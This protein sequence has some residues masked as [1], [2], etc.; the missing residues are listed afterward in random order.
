MK[1]SLSN[2]TAQMGGMFLVMENDNLE[3]L[4]NWVSELK[5]RCIPA[6]IKVSEP[7]LDQNCNVLKEVSERGFD[8]FGA[9]DEE[10][11][12]DASYEYQFEKISR[13]KEKVESCTSKPM[14]LFCAKFLSYNE[15]TL[16]VADKLG[17]EY[18]FVLGTAGA[19]AVI[20]KTDEYNTKIMSV[21]S[22]TPANKGAGSLCDHAMSSL[23]ETPDGFRD[24]LFGLKEDYIILVGWTYLSG[25]NLEWRNVFRDFFDAGR[26]TWRSIDEFNAE[27]I[28]LPFAKVP[29][30][31]K[32]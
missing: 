21:S 22:V 13:I 23:G 28:R 6:V 25:V 16:K 14:R 19:R 9:H 17:I 11:L 27:I 15:N 8:I 5:E 18:I 7:L 26:V 32:D 3:G 4:K 30:N 2:K 24:I 12:W 31:R 29:V 1:E 10:T 20:Y